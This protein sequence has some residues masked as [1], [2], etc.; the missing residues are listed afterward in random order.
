MQLSGLEI[1]LPKRPAPE[2]GNDTNDSSLCSGQVIF[3]ADTMDYV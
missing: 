3:G 2:V 1:L